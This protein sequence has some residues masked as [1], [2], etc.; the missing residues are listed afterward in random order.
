M[1]YLI[2]FH[3]TTSFRTDKMLQ[4]FCIEMNYLIGTSELKMRFY[5]YENQV[6]TLLRPF[7]I[8]STISNT[9]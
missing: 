2:E 1:P 9:Q 6:F 5:C 3:A 8:K 7:D 4:I